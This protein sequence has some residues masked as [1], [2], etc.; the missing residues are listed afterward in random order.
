MVVGMSNPQAVA[1]ALLQH[2]GPLVV[3]AHVDPDGDALGSVLALSRALR[4]C[5]KVVLAPM[6]DP[7]RYLAF[8]HR[9][10]ELSPPLEELPAEAMV[11]LLDGDAG[12]ASGAPIAQSPLINIDHHQS[13]QGETGLCWIDPTYAAAAL[14]VC[15]VIDALGVAW[16]TELATPALT[17][18]I[19]DTGHFRFANTDRRVLERAG[20]LIESG[21][22]YADL[23][24]RLQWRHLDHYRMLSMVLGTLQR[25]FGGE[26]LLARQSLAMRA[27]LGPSDDDSDDFVQHYRYAEGVRIAALLKE[28]E[29]A[30]KVSVRSRGGLSARR[31]CASLGGG[32][33]EVAAGATLSGLTLDEAEMRLLEAVRAE[34][35]SAP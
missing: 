12:R 26:M 11:V 2:Q 1:H 8:L 15:D 7:P 16:S 13:N 17:G 9:A 24:D 29:G 27:S 34:L 22:D 33:H 6:I 31:I 14:M 5:G 28:R 3:L 20:Q 21:V 25:H 35:A 4:S 19:S 30:I 32:G 10:G 23:S 18:I